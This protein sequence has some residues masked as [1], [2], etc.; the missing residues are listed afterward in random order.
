M[1]KAPVATW[2]P[3]LEKVGA[4]LD[5]RGKAVRLLDKSALIELNVQRTVFS[6][7]QQ[8][9]PAVFDAIKKTRQLQDS[10]AARQTA[11]LLNE[12][13]ARQ[14]MA[15]GDAAWLQRR[16]RDQ[17]LAMPWAEVE[18]TVR[19]LR[20]QLA[21]TKPEDIETFVIRKLDLSAGVA[22][23]KAS[24]GFVM[25]LMAMRFQLLEVMPRRDALV[26]GLDEAIARR[27]A[28]P[29]SAVSK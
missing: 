6:Q 14:A 3:L 4:A 22:E 29:A 23:H 9:W 24:L 15:G 18:P 11:G 27:S 13:L 5:E 19:T 21:L 2:K 25:Q 8:A 16:L 7:M 17:V 28:A 10:V 20:E 12:V 1:L 26:A